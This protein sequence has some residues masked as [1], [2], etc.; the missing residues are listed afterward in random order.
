MYAVGLRD[1]LGDRLGAGGEARPLEHA[2]RPVPEDG[3]RRC[4]PGRERLAR[5]GADV[6]PEPALG[7]SVVGHDLRVG[8]RAEL[9][10]RDDVDRK[11]N[12]EPERI[13]VAQLLGHLAADQ[14]LVGTA[15]E[16]L[17]DADLVV[18]F[19][20]AGD[21]HERMLHLAEQPPQLLQLAL[22]QQAGVGGQDLRDADG[23]GMRAMCGAE[24]VVHVEIE[25]VRELA[26]EVRIVRL[27]A[28]VEARVLQDADPLVRRSSR[29]RASTGFIE[30]AGS[31]PFGRPRCEQTTISA[32][33]RSNS[34]SSVGSEA[35]IRVSSATC[36][37][38]SGTFRS[39]RTRARLPA[40]SA[41]RTDRGFRTKASG[42]SNRRSDTS[43]PTRCRTSR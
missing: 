17:Q 8:V 39:A 38:S 7:Q 28:G 33:P 31:S 30:N 24:G 36:P 5:L 21:E 9:G 15:P 35:R 12:L 23:G 22:E 34:S 1:R 32:A 42:R 25:A 3:L 29:S 40:T 20:P 6:E 37:S 26:G 4:D 41:S 2:H 16:V 11:P 19:R 18:D 10:G 14:H 27:L 43:S 13:L